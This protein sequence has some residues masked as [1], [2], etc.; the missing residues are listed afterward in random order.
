MMPEEAFFCKFKN[1]YCLLP[2][3]TGIQIKNIP[4]Q[5][6]LISFKNI[7]ENYFTLFT[8]EQNNFIITG[9][10]RK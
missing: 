4:S 5:E 3:Q 10:W 7:I 2:L 1:K 6:K 8:E 9:T